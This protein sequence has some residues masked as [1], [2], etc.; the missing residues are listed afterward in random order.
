MAVTRKQNGEEYYGLS[1]DVKPADSQINSLFH[2]LDTNDTYYNAIG[3]LV[4]FNRIMAT[5]DG[6]VPGIPCAIYNGE[7]EP[8]ARVGLLPGQ[9]Y[10]VTYDGVTYQDLIAD[11][12]NI[13]GVELVVLGTEGIL[14][15]WEPA[16]GNP[17]FYFGISTYDHTVL[18]ATTSATAGT[19][20][21]K[22]FKSPATF[23]Q[24]RKVGG[25]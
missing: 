21:V 20:E 2:E 8:K 13:E 5:V 25:N 18:L 22:I 4:V 19:H 1:T 6:A 12:K 3:S 23:N 14:I 16:S 11:V 9:N 24:W 7:N 10:S 17:P 15:G